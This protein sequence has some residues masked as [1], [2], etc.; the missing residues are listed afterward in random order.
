[1]P[2][3]QS[4]E[5]W[6]A[7]RCVISFDDNSTGEGPPLIYEERITLWRAQG[8]DE[9]IERAEAEAREYAEVLDASYTGLAQA[10]HLA[11]EGAV[12]DGDEIFSLMRRNELAP[13]D[14][15]NRF[16]STGQEHQRHVE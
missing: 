3:S 11:V 13:R 15:L 7:V 10:F 5:P 6:Y 8:F 2:R 9:A 1:M 12:G 4:D 14:Y 16:F